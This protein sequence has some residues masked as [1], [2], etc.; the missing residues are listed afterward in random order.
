MTLD[1]T[2]LNLIQQIQNPTITIF[3]KII[4]LIFDPITLTIIA[5]ATSIYLA[6][7]S[8][9]KQS[10]LLASTILI[11]AA[12]I[13]ILKNI[14]QV[15]RPPNPIITATGFSFPSGHVTTSVVFLGLIIYI[16]TK[17]NS[18]KTKIATVLIIFAVVLSRIYLRVHWL[19]DIL[20]GLILGLII[21]IIAIQI[22]NKI[23]FSK[24]NKPHNLSQP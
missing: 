11:T 8:Q 21:L 10:I 20:A 14:L 23:I 4:S 5:I 6:A 19:T 9:K 2:T 16:F 22:F 7:K 13:E 24:S 3:A 12:I 15:A 1:T 17:N 18:A